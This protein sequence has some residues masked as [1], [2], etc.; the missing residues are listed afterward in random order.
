MSWDSSWETV[1]RTRGWSVYPQEQLVRSVARHY[2][3]VVE[4][5]NVKFLELGCGQGNNIWY[6]AREGFSA[7]GVDG[8]ATAIAKAKEYLKADGLA[9]DLRVGDVA[10]L[11]ELYRGAQFDAI[12]DAGCLQHNDFQSI[13][14]ILH[15]V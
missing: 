11:R 10:Y 3:G 2:Y 15:Q 6:L 4:R 9:A 12:V 1:F 8:S 13:R 14:A 7:F 5:Q